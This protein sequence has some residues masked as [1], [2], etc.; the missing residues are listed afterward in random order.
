MKTCQMC[1]AEK[2]EV[3][4]VQVVP[5]TWTSFHNFVA[6]CADCQNSERFAKLLKQRKIIVQRPTKPA[7]AAPT[8]PA[9]PTSEQ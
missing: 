8:A 5:A 1:A 4:L 7:A 6:I 9:A 3:S 2:P